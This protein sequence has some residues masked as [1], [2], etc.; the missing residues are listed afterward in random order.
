MLTSDPRDL[1][2]VTRERSRHLREEASAER[3]RHTTGTRS[4]LAWSLRRL[5]DRIDPPLMPRPV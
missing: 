4:A 3:L 5:A 2:L 1:L